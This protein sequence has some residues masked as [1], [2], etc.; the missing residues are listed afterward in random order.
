M[1]Q[2]ISNAL[3]K[4]DTLSKTK[5]I[6]I[7]S[8]LDTDGITSAAIFGR[9]LQRWHK[10]YSL[11]IIKELEESFIAKL[12]ETHILIFLGLASESLSA[13]AQKK[14]EIFIFDHHEISADIP[15]NITII[16]LQLVQ[17][18]PLSS[19]AICY[20]TARTLAAQNKDLAYLAVLGMVGN[21]LE[22]NISP[23]YEEILREAETVIKRGLLLYPAT[24]PL[25]KTLEYCSNPYIPNVTGSYRGVIE[26]LR[27]AHIVRE[28]DKFKSLL[29]L[30]DNEMGRLITA[31]AMRIPQRTLEQN[32]GNL[33][34]IKFFNQQA[35]ARELS[36]LI[37][38]C[39]RM[40]QPALALS[41]CL[42]NK[43]AKEQAER[44]YT[45]YKQHL[46]AGLK[47]AQE[48]THITG[49]LYTIINA[50]DK[51][52][53]TIIGTV[54]SMLS[55]SPAFE[56]GTA[57]IGLAY[58]NNKIKISAQM[59]GK[60]GRNVHELVHNIIIKLG[61]EIGGQPF[62]TGGLIDKDKEQLFITEL[63]SSL[64]ITV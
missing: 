55:A 20:L 7:I 10:T 1:Q 56:E 3:A 11:Q 41:F 31:I 46:I 18:E 13:L 22:K 50:Q 8:H 64:K 37:N 35:D 47:Y 17:A 33:Y 16:N 63:Q 45:E 43:E 14:T 30:S 9:M 42:G 54:T 21:Q 62:A 19:A 61:G 32:I 57:L 26:L 34:I 4:I 36:A 15:Q 6:K 23:Q 28:Q 49:P 51:I 44:L 24:R 25:D 48:N 39:S 40:D 38:A 59:V 5:P 29:E 58:A 27:D 12:P 52:K 60:Q 53:D 2:A